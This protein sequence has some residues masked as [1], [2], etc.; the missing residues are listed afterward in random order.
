[1]ET[2]LISWFTTA[3][4]ETLLKTQDTADTAESSN[5][6][7][8][9]PSV[10]F[11]DV[12]AMALA[13]EPPEGLPPL[14]PSTGVIDPQMDRMM[15]NLGLATDEAFSWELVSLGLEE[16]LPSQEIITDMFVCF[17]ESV[18]YHT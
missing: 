9:M 10:N 12:P 7:P 1:M 4:V 17:W 2:V 14:V 6:M 11:S 13:S 3:Q 5:T 15:D 8:S 18:S 16:P